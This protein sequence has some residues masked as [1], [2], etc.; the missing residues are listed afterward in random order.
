MVVIIIVSRG[1]D[2]DL[3]L[4]WTSFKDD[5]LIIF[6]DVVVVVEFASPNPKICICKIRDLNDA[7]V[8]ISIERKKDIT[9]GSIAIRASE[10]IRFDLI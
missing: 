3:K 8:A 9:T 10:I 2:F 7:S 1:T 4:L 6:V 5:F